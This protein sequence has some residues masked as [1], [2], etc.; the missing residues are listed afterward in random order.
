MASSSA[1]RKKSIISTI[2]TP[3]ASNSVLN[4]T[5]S[6]SNSLYHQCS[7]LRSRL[8]RLKGFAPFFSLASHSVDARQSTD[9][10][11]LLWD[12]F[13]LGYPLV[14]I[15]NLL[16]E[17]FTKVPLDW[18]PETFDV[19]NERA[20]KRGIA[21]FAMQMAHVPSCERFTVTDLWDHQSTDGL[22]KVHVNSLNHI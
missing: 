11:T 13:S 1:A 8:L 20:K 12:L 4:T 17:P 7:S 18:T 9:P 16:P 5:A 14:Y 2:D 10:V 6:Q 15:Y 21:L 19:T 22:V 3:V